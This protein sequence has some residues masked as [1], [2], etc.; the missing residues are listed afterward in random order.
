MPQALKNSNHWLLESLK[1]QD[2]SKISNRGFF[3]NIIIIKLLG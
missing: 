2:A 3:V 1:I